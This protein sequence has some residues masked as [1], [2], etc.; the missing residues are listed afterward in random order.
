MKMLIAYAYLAWYL[1]PPALVLWWARRWLLTPWARYVSHEKCPV[2]N[3][4]KERDHQPWF[5]TVRH[6]HWYPPFTD[7][8]VTYRSFR[9]DRW[10]TFWAREGTGSLLLEG[11]CRLLDNQLIIAES[12]VRETEELIK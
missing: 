6:V 9:S 4:D 2:L 3:T 10:H 7:Y 1:M 5:M 8:E 12:R 11:Q